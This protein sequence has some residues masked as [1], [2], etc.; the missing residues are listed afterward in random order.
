[1]GDQ[2][3]L[4]SSTLMRGKNRITVPK[5]VERFGIVS[6]DRVVFWAYDGEEDVV[7][8]SQDQAIFEG[9]ERYDVLEGYRLGRSYVSEYPVEIVEE[10]G[11]WEMGDHVLFVATEDEVRNNVVRVIPEEQFDDRFSPLFT[12]DS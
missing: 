3:F 4:G 2:Y 5:I 8:A 1:M 11:Y 10:Y 12:E 7:V 9:E 6:T